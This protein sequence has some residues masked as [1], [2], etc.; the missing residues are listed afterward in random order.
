MV[1]GWG[2]T[3]KT[4]E[5]SMTNDYPAAP[6]QAQKKGGFEKQQMGQVTQH[7]FSD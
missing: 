5:F 3:R 6:D 7:R 2:R 1:G 4:F